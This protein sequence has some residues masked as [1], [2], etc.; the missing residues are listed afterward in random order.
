[1]Q[2][3]CALCFLVPALLTACASQPESV[4]DGAQPLTVEEILASSPQPED[5]SD[6]VSCLS[7]NAYLQV[8]VINRKLLVFHGRRGKAWLN[9]LRSA[10]IGVRREDTLAFDLRNGRL[11]DLDT[12]SSI[13]AFGGSMERSSARCSLGKFEPISLEQ[14]EMLKEGLAP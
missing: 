12:F 9:R 7:R 8:D 4:R 10:C 14:A 5:Y 6:P 3:C 1:M 11:C 2:R 13:D